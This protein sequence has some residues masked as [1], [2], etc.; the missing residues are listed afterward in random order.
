MGDTFAEG[1]GRLDLTIDAIPA[2][3]WSMTPDGLLEFCNQ[4]MLE[5]VGK[6]VEEI[7]GPGFRS[8]F[9]PDDVPGVLA[10]WREIAGT[11]RGREIDVRIRRA[12]GAYRWFMLRQDPLLDPHGTVVKCHGVG[13]DIELRKRAE[14]ALKEAEAAS[15]ASA[16]KLNLIINS[17]PVQVWSARADGTADFVNQGWVD[18]AG[19]P[20]DKILDRG[21]LDFCHPDDAKGLMEAWTRDIG[22]SDRISYKGRICGQD[23]QPRWFYF[24]GRKRID[25]HGVARWY[26]VNVDIDDV[27]RAEDALRE[28]EHRL[29]QVIDAIPAMAWSAAADGMLEFWNR[30]LS[31]FVGLPF[32]QI[33]GTGFY[34]IFHPD[35]VELLRDAWEYTL[36]TK[37]PR[38]VDGRIRRADGEYRWFTFRQNPL[39]DEQGNVVR[40]YGIIID[41]EDRKRAEDALRASQAALQTREHE[42]HQIISSVPGLVWS[43]DEDGRTE[44]WS[45]QYLDYAGVRHEDVLGLGYLDHIH[46][47]DRQLAID[48]SAATVTSRRAG[49]IEIRLCRA[50]GQ[51]RWF[52]I[53]ASPF[54][55]DA[56]NITRWF[57]VNIDIEERK[58]AEEDLRQSRCDLE[59]VSRLTTMGELAVSIAHEVNQ[60]LMA[61][62]TNAS[63]C[64]RWLDPAQQ[65]L[66][67]AR[68]AVG[69]IVRDG[70]RAGD[71]VASVRALAQKSP[72][73]MRRM[74]LE[75]AIREVLGLLRAE[76]Q[77]RGIVLVTEF[78]PAPTEVIGDGTQ[79]QQVILNLIMNSVEAMSGADSPLRR[80]TIRTLASEDFA[81]FSVL[82]TGG[83]LNPDNVDRLFEA[84]FTTKPEGI[85][86]GLSI[87][88]SIVEA[89]RG[90]IWASDNTPTGSVFSVA[91]PLAGTTNARPD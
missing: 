23:G 21:F 14:R 8:I 13:S 62:V 58:R 20:A 85:G 12:D 41:I 18:Y 90:R 68:E 82:D 1:E 42:L 61:I 39:L 53:R 46:P 66:A 31:D 48:F 45:P 51:F 74:V 40:W 43:S 57:G 16:Q 77:H 37:Q 11:R 55:D 7:T 73:K 5:F 33:V 79:L 63:T 50:D 24:A 22:H 32:D 80:L 47:E 2:L 27:Q 81:Q 54:Y 52:L 83:G 49:E 76:F 64:L 34:R 19:C 29:R 38:E 75:T 26:G 25:A 30:T 69:R 56:G 60:P 35:D 6:T 15:R 9:H 59:H 89:H 91:L 3:A 71:I 4:P 87:C 17:L 28:S 88:R 67:L 72:L 84:F 65:D 44:Y 36:A 10:A 70:H 78:A 86:M